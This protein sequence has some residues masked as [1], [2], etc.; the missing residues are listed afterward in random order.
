MS[1]KPGRSGGAN[2]AHT[3][4]A[5]PLQVASWPW[6]R[7]RKP[8]AQSTIF[9]HLAETLESWGVT[10]DQACG[11]LVRQMADAH[12]MRMEAVRALR[13]GEHK[14]HG[15]AALNVISKSNAAI[16]SGLR[17]LGIYPLPKTRTGADDDAAGGADYE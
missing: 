10:R 7:A 1:G 3:P 15:A 5:A 14:V 2:R 8:W 13:R 17:Q 9:K 6:E 11:D 12:W 16:V 4:A